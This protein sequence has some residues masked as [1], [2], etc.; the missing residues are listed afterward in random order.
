M[1][2]SEYVAGPE[3]GAGNDPEKLHMVRLLKGAGATGGR[4]AGM[5][6]QKL[7]RSQGNMQGGDQFGLDVAM[8]T[9]KD[10]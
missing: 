9:L 1:A 3:G 7:A 6:G 8:C 5:I 10:L 4:K 2:C